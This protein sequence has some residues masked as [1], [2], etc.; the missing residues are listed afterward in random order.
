LGDSSAALIIPVP[1]ELGRFVF[2]LPQA[3]G[4]SYV[5]ITDNPLRG[6]IPEQITAPVS[7][8]SWIVDTVS[9]V[10]KVPLTI[11]DVVGTYAGM[12]PLVIPPAAR[13][14]EGAADQQDPSRTTADISRRHI[15]AKHDNIVTVTGGNLT[16]YRRMAN[17]A[18]DLISDRPSLTTRVSLVGAGTKPVVAG[19]PDRLWRR[20]GNEAP[21]VWDIGATDPH[22]RAPIAEDLS[23]LG[24]ELVFGREQEL[25]LGV[26]DLLD[27]RTRV[28]LVP[29][30]R[31]R[32]HT[33]AAAL[34]TSEE[35]A[36]SARHA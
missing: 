16:T 2:T 4:L 14:V 23:V 10:L 1:G 8:I 11:A 29:T 15:V 5:G 30:D 19:I 20:Y 34:F 6:P 28:G 25:A 26:D 36:S 31:D 27:R 13:G 35:S 3:D 22:L 32:A 7:D 18:V 33:V 21:I 17:E 9:S 24:V 12:R